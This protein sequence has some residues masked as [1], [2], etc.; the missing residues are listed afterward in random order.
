MYINLAFFRFLAIDWLKNETTNAMIRPV[1]EL[2]EKI[3]HY[4]Y[5]K[6]YIPIYLYTNILQITKLYKGIS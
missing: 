5:L 4:T 3:I 6:T 2:Y 1:V